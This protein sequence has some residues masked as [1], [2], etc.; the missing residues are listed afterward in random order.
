MADLNKKFEK[1]VLKSPALFQTY[2]F[3]YYI[4]HNELISRKGESN[5]KFKYFIFVK[6]VK[7]HLKKGDAFFLRAD[8]SFDYKLFVH[9]DERY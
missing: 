9:I 3:V 1:N 2:P 5:L 7:T 4:K 6:K 8:L